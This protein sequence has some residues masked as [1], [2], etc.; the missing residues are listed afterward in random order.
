MA[1]SP[2]EEPLVQGDLFDGS[3][4]AEPPTA[5]IKS[6]SLGEI[7]PNLRGIPDRNAANRGVEGE[8]ESRDIQEAKARF[9]QAGLEWERASDL[10]VGNLEQL[11]GRIEAAKK[12]LEEL[13]NKKN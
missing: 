2:K 7:I 11:Q 6:K 4:Q 8:E 9:E 10:G 12:N 3:D 1:E 13:L 5:E